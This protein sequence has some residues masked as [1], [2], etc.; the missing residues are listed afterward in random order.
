MSSGS[1]P[2]APTV[3]GASPSRLRLIAGTLG[4]VAALIVGFT[5]PAPAGHPQL[6][7]MAGAAL[8]MALYWTF[9]VLPIAV[10]SLLP[11]ALFPLL[12]VAD[13]GAV[14]GAYGKPT[15]YLFL[16]GF[17]LALGI[18][19]TGLHRRIALRIVAF[20]GTR[21][22]RLVL[23]FMV[24][25]GLLSMW[26]SNTATVMVMLPIAAAVLRSHE[27][28]ATDHGAAPIPHFGTA[29]M[30]GIAYAANIGGMGTLVG[31][32][33]NLAYRQILHEVFPAA[34]E[35][36]FGGWMLLGAPLAVVFLGIGWLVLTRFIFRLPTTRAFGERNTIRDARRALGPVRRD[37]LLAGLVFGAVALLWVTGSGFGDVPGW[38]SLP[39]LAKVGDESVAIAGAIALFVIP[40]GERRGAIMDWETARRLPWG[41]LLLFGGGFAL[42]AGFESSGLSAAIGEG[43][44]GLAGLPPW[45]L[46]VIVSTVMTFLTELTSNT[47]TANLV[48]PI[49]AKAAVAM[50]VD[51]R[52]LMIPATLSA[53]CAFMMP[54]ATPTNAIVFGAGHIT[55]P[56]MAWAGL[57]LNLVGVVLVTAAFFLLGTWALAIAPAVVPTWAQG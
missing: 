56:Q 22:S 48:L 18:E 3:S 47:A 1:A 31:T 57:W 30:L 36:T 40:S 33:P 50:G 55:V 39:G 32:P 28:A 45:L 14:A 21:P 49:L 43:L 29:L 37:E 34:P 25:S 52:A 20:L 11:L 19:R 24:A 38:R 51:P 8:L 46:V 6:P 2:H 15:T 7:A 53:S 17:I 44:A 23:G 4:A 10:T 42:A 27:E 12:G 54:V 13:P 41:I 35:V 16:G 5:V 9:D 26:I